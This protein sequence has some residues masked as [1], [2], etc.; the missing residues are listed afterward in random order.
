MS[1]KSR[2]RLQTLYSHPHPR[3]ALNRLAALQRHV[4]VRMQRLPVSSTTWP[5]AP[6]P[7]TAS[8]KQPP[9]VQA[10]APPGAPTDQYRQVAG[11]GPGGRGPGGSTETV[12]RIRTQRG[13][14]SG[15]SQPRPAPPLALPGLRVVCEGFSW[16]SA[17]D[18]SVLEGK[19]RTRALK[20]AK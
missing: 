15:H 19:S 20:I 13:T 14:A 5:P 18:M 8:T 9:L 11:G 17:Q 1:A 6:G 12:M 10:P 2:V 16:L 4:T 7:S 3:L